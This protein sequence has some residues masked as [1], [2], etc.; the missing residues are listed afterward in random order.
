[1]EITL[2]QNK[3]NLVRKVALFYIF[4]DIVVLIFVISNA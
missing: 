2:F 1:M 3:I 4:A